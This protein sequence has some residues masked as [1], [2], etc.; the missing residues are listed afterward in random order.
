MT[1]MK[2]ITL[3]K[4]FKL[5]AIAA[6]ALVLAGCASVNFD[7]AVGNA[8]QTTGSFTGG[9]LALSQTADQRDARAKLSA[10]LLSKPLT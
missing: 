4:Y 3:T 7:E 6:A 2:T 9:K 8:N 5:T 10:D 1:F